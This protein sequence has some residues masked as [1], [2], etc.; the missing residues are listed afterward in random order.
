MAGTITVHG[1][2]ITP[3]DLVL[4]TPLGVPDP[5][6][7]GY[8]MVGIASYYTDTTVRRYRQLVKLEPGTPDPR[9]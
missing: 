1:V 7:S 8:E 5:V 9:D 6:I 4:I 2:V 3:S